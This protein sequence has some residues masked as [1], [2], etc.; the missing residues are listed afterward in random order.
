M[1]AKW[2]QQG[3]KIEAFG[4]QGMIFW[5][6]DGLGQ[7]CFF[8]VLGGLSKQATKSK[9]KM[10]FGEKKRPSR[11]IVIIQLGPLKL[12]FRLFQLTLD[13]FVR[14]RQTPAGV[15]G[16]WRPLDLEGVPQSTIFL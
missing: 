12:M 4:V 8:D 6:F 2:Y 9:R 16:F 3:I 15:G 10:F 5:D 1:A 7:A 14:Q 11:W 13:T